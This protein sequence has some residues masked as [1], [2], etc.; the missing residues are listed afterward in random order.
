MKQELHPAL[1]RACKIYTTRLETATI[2]TTSL[3]SVLNSL[4]TLKCSADVRHA[5]GCCELDNEPPGQKTETP[6]CSVSPRPPTRNRQACGNATADMQPKSMAEGPDRKAEGTK[7]HTGVL[8]TNQRADI[9][10]TVLSGS[11]RAGPPMQ[12]RI[13]IVAHQCSAFASS[14]SFST[15]PRAS[16][17]RCLD[18]LG[19]R[20]LM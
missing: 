10:L 8:S 17:R 15:S 7:H 19:D 14:M 9:W 18:S 13:Y 16:Q 12:L 1:L 3:S 20:R 2:H 5:Y 11:F 4:T 6:S